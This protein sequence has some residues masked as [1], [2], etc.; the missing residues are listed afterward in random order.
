MSHGVADLLPGNVDEGRRTYTTTLALPRRRPRT[1]RISEGRAGFARVEAERRR[2]GQREADDVTT[3]VRR[4]LNL[5]EDLSDFYAL[6]ADDPD[7]S[8]AASGAGRMLRTPTVFEAVVKTICTTNVALASIV[9]PPSLVTVKRPGPG[10]LRVMDLLGSLRF[11][12]VIFNAP[13]TSVA[14][15]AKVIPYSLFATTWTPTSNEQLPLILK[16]A[17][18]MNSLVGGSAPA[19]GTSTNSAAMK[20][21]RSG[22]LGFLP[23]ELHGF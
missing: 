22:G 5:D 14:P 19:V 17:A 21:P 12:K 3:A 16:S 15:L 23:R 6:V 9:S 10:T 2:L 8:W 4:I 20:R 7:L 13:V 1:I 11:V 18:G